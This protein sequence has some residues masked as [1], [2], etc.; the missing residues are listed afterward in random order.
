MMMITMRFSSLP[1]WLVAIMATLF[2]TPVRTTALGAETS[3][4]AGSPRIVWQ[5]GKEDQDYGDFALAGNNK[6][7]QLKFPP[8]NASL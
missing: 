2:L 3:N 6:E 8:K 7:Y 1:I 4:S 5:I